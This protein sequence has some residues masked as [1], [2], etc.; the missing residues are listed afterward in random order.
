MR[1]CAAAGQQGCTVGAAKKAV[2]RDISGVGHRGLTNLSASMR[3]T[4][5]SHGM[6]F[7]HVLQ[8]SLFF[9]LK[10][11]H[12]RWFY[13]RSRKRYQR[14]NQL[15]LIQPTEASFGLQY[16]CSISFLVLVMFCLLYSWYICSSWFSSIASAVALASAV[17]PFSVCD[18]FWHI[19]LLTF[20]ILPTFPKHL[21]LSLSLSLSLAVFYVLKLWQTSRSNYKKN[22]SVLGKL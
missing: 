10:K 12:W 9:C 15:L 19:L 1:G 20:S 6:V 5:E 17:A 7:R 21:S 8:L 16:F 3:F 4:G 18:I 11:A 14:F 2:I 22:V 13:S